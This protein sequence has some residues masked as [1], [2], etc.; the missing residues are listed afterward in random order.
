MKFSI[1][2][3]TANEWS[4][5]AEIAAYADKGPWHALYIADHFMPNEAEPS[6]GPM[7]ECWSVVSA[8]AAATERVRLANLVLST[9]YR[10]P[11]VLANMAATT[12]IIADGRLTLGLGA[13]WQLNEHAA[14]GIELGTVR[15]RMDRFEEACAIVTGM[16]RNERTTL[17][18]QHYTVTDA[19]CEPKPVGDVPFLIGGGGEQRTLR[20]TARYADEWNVWS[21]PSVFRHKN[22]V[23]DQRC[24]EIDRDPAEIHR[25]TQ[26]LLFLS[27]DQERLRQFRDTDL[28]RATVVGTPSELIEELNAYAAA[29]AQEF[30]V[31][32]FT[33]G[34]GERR[35]EILELFREAVLPHVD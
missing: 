24:A 5:V 32:D 7:L 31:P 27:E 28:G 19:P 33:L 10:H 16:L 34:T 6:L 18:G 11:A 14:Y 15:E 23:L 8:L 12:D 29:G 13:G 2:T 21:V 9:T 3:N 35:I 25:S 26:A 30:I 1:W 22:N 20:I 4:D 17:E